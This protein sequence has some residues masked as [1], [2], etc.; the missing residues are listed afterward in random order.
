MSEE[1]ITTNRTGFRADMGH[2]QLQRA[3]RRLI[4]RSVMATVGPLYSHVRC[5]RTCGGDWSASIWAAETSPCHE[6]EQHWP[7]WLRDEQSSRSN[8]G[9]TTT[10]AT[11]RAI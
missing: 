1:V 2:S 5:K 4:T 3:N 9:M 7:R 8:C 6:C 11:W 10:G